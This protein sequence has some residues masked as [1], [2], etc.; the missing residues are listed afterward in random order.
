MQY[1]HIKL[2]KT[3][4]IWNR[5]NTVVGDWCGGFSF[6]CDAGVKGKKAVLFRDCPTLTL[7]LSLDSQV[8]CQSQKFITI[9]VQTVSVSSFR[10]KNIS[11]LTAVQKLSP[12]SLTWDLSL[13][14]LHIWA[15]KH[16]RLACANNQGDNK[17]KSSAV[18]VSVNLLLSQ[19]M[20]QA[21]ILLTSIS[22]KAR[23]IF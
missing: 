13:V 4:A 21:Q 12:Y 22:H 5:F 18:N 23:N 3:S 9:S 20:S 1:R 6:A 10:K 16:G 8:R 14:T 17:Q 2:V 19:M 7:G 15:Y 11:T